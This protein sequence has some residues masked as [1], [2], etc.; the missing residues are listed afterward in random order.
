MSNAAS[1]DDAV[2]VGRAVARSNLFKCAVFGEDPNWGRILSRSAPLGAR[3]SR[4]R[5][6]VAVNGVWVCRAG[7]VGET[8][9]WST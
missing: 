6:D 2:D 1:E 9:T 3:S 7:G 8:G 4:T 5:I